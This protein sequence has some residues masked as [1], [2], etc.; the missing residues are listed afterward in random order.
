MKYT[1]AELWMG[2]LEDRGRCEGGYI[3]ELEDAQVAYDRL[4]HEKP[5]YEVVWTRIS[6]TASPRPPNFAHIG[7]EPT[8]FTGDHF[9]ASCD[10]MLIPRWHGTDEEGRLFIDYF[11]QLN[12]HGLFPSSQQAESFLEY[13]LSFDWTETGDH[14]IAEIFLPN[15]VL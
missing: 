12:R 15:E 2:E 9:S 1:D 14:E 11:G 13:Y 10:C 8:W 7:Y 6:G 3:F 4:G 5:D